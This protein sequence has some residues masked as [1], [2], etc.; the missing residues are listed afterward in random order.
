MPKIVYID[1]S[2]HPLVHNKFKS[3]SKSK[4]ERNTNKVMNEP[5]I[6]LPKTLNAR[7]HS[8]AEKVT[9]CIIN[10]RLI[11]NVSSLHSFFALD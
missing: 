3:S 4:L 10:Y 6:L 11:Q 2:E 9:K 1:N 7:L 8:S 5:C